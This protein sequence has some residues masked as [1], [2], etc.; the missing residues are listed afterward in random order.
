M[1]DGSNPLEE[2]QRQILLELFDQ[3]VASAKPQACLPDYLPAPPKSGRVFLFAGGKAAGAMMEVAERIYRED[4]GLGTDRLLG[5]AITRNGYG[6]P[7]GS[8]PLIEAGHPVPNQAGV[9]AT[10][11]LLELAKTANEEDLVVVLLSGGGSANWI[12]PVSGVSLADKQTLTKT[13]LRSGADI[14]EI[15]IL[16]KHLSDLKGGRLARAVFPARLITLAISDV[17]GDDPSVIASGPTVG[18]TSTLADARLILKRFAP[19]APPCIHHALLD[20]SNESPLPDD[21]I[22]EHSDY[23]MVARPA[24]AL[25]ATASRAE[26]A[27]YEPIFLGDAVEGEARIIARA[28]AKMAKEIARSGRRAA[29]LSGG[30]LTVTLK[31]DGRGGP[32]QEYALAI[33]MAL[34]GHPLISAIAGDT[35]GTDGGNGSRNDPAGALV[36]P[37]ILTRAEAQGLD[38]ASFLARN[39]STGFFEKTGDLVVPGPTFTNVNDFRA[40]IIDNKGSYSR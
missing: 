26:E 11:R 20:E 31:G 1:T 22:F 24:M 5:L 14:E 27:G 12:A 19:D 9:D 34:D 17:P 30:E 4:Y 39:D 2:S 21:A 23:I 38:A 32:N 7:T 15:N 8:L 3:A 35:D 29:L 25:E 36:G 37:S 16:R 40:L 28:H 18:D 33:A 13:L 10:H 6:R